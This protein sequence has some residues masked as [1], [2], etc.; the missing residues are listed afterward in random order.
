MIWSEKELANIALGGVN[1]TV[2]RVLKHLGDPENSDIFEKENFSLLWGVLGVA[3]IKGIPN[4]ALDKVWKALKDN[5]VIN[6]FD[7]GVLD[8]FNRG[9]MKKY[10]NDNR[11]R[12]WLNLDNF[13][14]D[15]KFK[16]LILM[17]IVAIKR[18]FAHDVDM[19]AFNP[20]RVVGVLERYPLSEP[21]K[22]MLNDMQGHGA[23]CGISGKEVVENYEKEKVLAKLCDV[24][25]HTKRK[26]E[27]DEKEFLFRYIHDAVVDGFDVGVIGLNDAV[28]SRLMADVTKEELS[29]I[30]ME[31]R[32]Q[33]NA[34]IVDFAKNFDGKY[35]FY[36][37]TAAKLIRYNSAHIQ[38]MIER[39]MSLMD[40]TD[41]KGIVFALE[42]IEFKQVKSAVKIIIE[43]AKRGR[44]TE[45]ASYLHRV[46]PNV[47]GAETMIMSTLKLNLKKLTE[48]KEFALSPVFKEYPSRHY[49][50]AVKSFI[51]YG[52]T[53]EAGALLLEL[54]N[55]DWVVGIKDL[56]DEC[57]FIAN[58]LVA[59]DRSLDS[60]LDV[61]ANKLN[62]KVYQADE[63]RYIGGE[64]ASPLSF[65]RKKAER[66]LSD[67]TGV[68]VSKVTSG[69]GSV[70]GKAYEAY[71]NIKGAL[72]LNKKEEEAK[73]EQVNVENLGNDLLD[74]NKVIKKDDV[75]VE[76]VEEINDIKEVDLSKEASAEEIN[77]VVKDVIEIVENKET[78]IDNSW[79]ENE[80]K[81]EINNIEVKEKE[82]IIASDINVLDNQSDKIVNWESENKEENSESLVK[83]INVGSLLNIDVKDVDKH[84]EKIKKVTSEALK[85]REE[86]DKI[87]DVT[88][89]AFKRV[90][91]KALEI[92]KKV[93]DR[94]DDEDIE[95]PPAVSKFKGLAKKIGL[96]KNKKN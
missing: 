45:L 66:F 72:G 91:E 43:L 21:I 6:A 62:L 73:E 25:A 22:M 52:F 38:E 13:T 60:T 15:L 93:E 75:K 46:I 1:V 20:L 26:L 9:I 27:E 24:I 81:E 12:A 70:E 84:F 83:K 10:P 54:I 65:M 86:F 53:K 3:G 32:R 77:E 82:E 35:G 69:L 50:H 7:Y 76:S 29:E 95:N 2:E 63:G 58:E 16:K 49:I 14:A 41:P 51:E 18:E 48:K 79:A 85:K 92:K 55:N 36:E 89:S 80:T 90:E 59:K 11:M 88:A 28:F 4:E 44:A 40:K 33:R 96:F 34:D 64:G 67:T 39:C 37:M 56:E 57:V 42:L 87:K 61:V 74:D 17:P 68:D 31:P 19:Q 78:V 23:A 5:D 47:K 30:E 94:M 8:D 71:K